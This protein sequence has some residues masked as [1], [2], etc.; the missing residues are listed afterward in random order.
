MCWESLFYF[1]LFLE[2]DLIFNLQHPCIGNCCVNIFRRILDL[3]PIKMMLD[4]LWNH[5][6]AFCVINKTERKTKNVITWSLFQLWHE[7]KGLKFQLLCQFFAHIH[8]TLCVSVIN[9][10][11]PLGWMWTSSNK[12]TKTRWR[13]F[14]GLTSQAIVVHWQGQERRICWKGTWVTGHCNLKCG[15]LSYLFRI[16]N[17]QILHTQPLNLASSFFPPRLRESTCHT[18]ICKSDSA[19]TSTSCCDA[20]F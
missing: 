4:G 16:K 10:W 1:I 7:R 13:T 12:S 6:K 19:A 20:C 5:I 3:W 11:Q 18:V 17:L 2:V 8:V 14:S 9:S 15:H